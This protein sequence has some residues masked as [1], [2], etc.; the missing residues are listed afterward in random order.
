M[1]TSPSL[2]THT[3]H[4]PSTSP[5]QTQY[6]SFSLTLMGKRPG[7]WVEEKGLLRLVAVILLTDKVWVV[8]DVYVDFHDLLV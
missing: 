7:L 2:V 1:K 5:H 4:P 3:P 8:E 6:T